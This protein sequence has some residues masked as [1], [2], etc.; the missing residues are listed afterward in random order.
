[1]RP[2]A[3][4]LMSGLFIQSRLKTAKTRLFSP[5]K[6]TLY[7]QPGDLSPGGVGVARIFG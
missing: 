7:G 1:L 4:T 5:L 2:P 6:R 3:R